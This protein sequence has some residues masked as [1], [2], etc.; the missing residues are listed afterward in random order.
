MAVVVAAPLCPVPADLHAAPASPPVTALVV[1][2]PAAAVSAWA[3]AEPLE[4]AAGEEVGR[5][6]ND[7]PKQA[8][9]RS[10]GASPSPAVSVLATNDSRVCSCRGVSPAERFNVSETGIRAAGDR[11]EDPMNLLSHSESRGKDGLSLARIPSGL[12]ED[13]REFAS[14]DRA[15]MLSPFRQILI[16]GEEI[17]RALAVAR[18]D[19]V[20]EIEAQP[21]TEQT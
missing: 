9:E 12:A 21:L 11:G 5:V 2:E 13:A 7:G 20:G 6:A 16:P 3:L 8:V 18:I 15:R 4:R 10:G 14:C 19:G 1:E 17:A